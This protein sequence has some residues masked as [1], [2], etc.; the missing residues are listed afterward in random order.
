MPL[1]ER[2]LPIIQKCMTLLL[3][4]VTF[5]EGKKAWSVDYKKGWLHNLGNRMTG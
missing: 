4:L 5:M 3:I 2:D 1:V